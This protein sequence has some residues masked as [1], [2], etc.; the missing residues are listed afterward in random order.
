M[1]DYPD[2]FLD[3]ILVKKLEKINNYISK[4]EHYF[5]YE[6]LSLINEK[7]KELK[8][9][10]KM[11][12]TSDN[13]TEKRDIYLR[14]KKNLKEELNYDLPKIL[15]L[16]SPNEIR[17]SIKEILVESKFNDK[18]ITDVFRFFGSG[19]NKER[20]PRKNMKIDSD[21]TKDT[22]THLGVDKLYKELYI[23]CDES[24]QYITLDEYHKTKKIKKKEPIKLSKEIAEKI[25][26]I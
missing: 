7:F 23:F 13:Y 4:G 15:P 9:L 19:D 25:G 20:A 21:I 24:N 10:A 22:I 17:I 14:A 6:T 8:K 5:N 26:L 3:T 16:N 1:N 2:M 18:Q 12:I 11:K